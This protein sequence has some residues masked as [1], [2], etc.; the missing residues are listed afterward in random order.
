M[1]KECE[2]KPKLQPT[3]RVQKEI[4][5]VDTEKC[6]H[7]RCPYKAE[8]SD[9]EATERDHA[10]RE[11]NEGLEPTTAKNDASTLGEKRSISV[12]RDCID[13]MRSKPCQITASCQFH[14][15]RLTLT[16]RGL[17]DLGDGTLASAYPYLKDYVIEADAEKCIDPLCSNKPANATLEET[18][19]ENASAASDDGPEADDAAGPTIVGCSTC[20]IWLKVS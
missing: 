14:G 18:E 11:S 4:I 6:M 5:L 20:V 1:D 15:V 12:C 8:K 19:T 9:A 10:S 7:A 13:L 16:E 3:V 17:V 2:E